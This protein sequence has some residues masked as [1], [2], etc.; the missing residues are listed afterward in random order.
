M[1]GFLRSGTMLQML[2]HAHARD[3]EHNL[4]RN[5]QPSSAAE[6]ERHEI[7]ER[8]LGQKFAPQTGTKY[9]SHGNVD[10][11]VRT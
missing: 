2:V 10:L 6:F 8:H 7:S 9:G 4:C 11:H 1:P 5:V 3:A